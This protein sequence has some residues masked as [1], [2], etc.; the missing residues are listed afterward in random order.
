MRQALIRSSRLMPARVLSE[1]RKQERITCA[2]P[3]LSASFLVY[4]IRAN[5]F[6]VSNRWRNTSV[7]IQIPE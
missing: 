1:L 3:A 2:G 5:V 4:I 6:N 7:T